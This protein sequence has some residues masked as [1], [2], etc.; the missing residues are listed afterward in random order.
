MCRFFYQ[1]DLSDSSR[2]ECFTVWNN[3]ITLFCFQSVAQINHESLACWKSF[4][5]GCSQLKK[6]PKKLW[7]SLKVETACQQRWKSAVWDIVFAPLL[8][9][10]LM[11][12]PGEAQCSDKWEATALPLFFPAC[13]CL[14]S[15]ESCCFKLN[16]VE[17]LWSNQ[18]QAQL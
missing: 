15:K 7:N 14:G 16:G 13:F 11:L 17:S 4:F 18:N 6:I 2:C 5:M 10:K 1:A 9:R 8:V 12:S 3:C